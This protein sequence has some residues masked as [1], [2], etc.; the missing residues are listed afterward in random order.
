M[1]SASRGP[2]E[3]PPT[4]FCSVRKAPMVSRGIPGCPSIS[5]RCHSKMSST[6]AGTGVAIAGRRASRLPTTLRAGSSLTSSVS[7][8]LG[9]EDPSRT[10]TNAFDQRRRTRLRPVENRCDPGQ[11]KTW[12][13]AQRPGRLRKSQ[14]HLR[15]K[16]E[17][18]S[19]KKLRNMR[20]VLIG[21]TKRISPRA[22]LS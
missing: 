20:C 9:L 4:Q 22:G 16:L 13:R 14:G 1:Y 3:P 15:G 12:D 18:S 7:G 10:W 19:G 5:R 21:A 8:E 6:L 2:N 17:L 11:R